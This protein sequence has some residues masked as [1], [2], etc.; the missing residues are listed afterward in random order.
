MVARYLPQFA[1][2]LATSTHEGVTDDSSRHFIPQVA[3]L[4]IDED[5]PI[6][7]GKENEKMLLGAG[8]IGNGDNRR[9]Y[10]LYLK[11]A[12]AQPFYQVH[13]P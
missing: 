11:K 12:R 8:Y 2:F 6:L 10:T 1:S 4:E 3:L 9:Y 7:N 5:H 13:F